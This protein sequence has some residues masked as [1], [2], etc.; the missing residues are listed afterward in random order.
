MR[1][2]VLHGVLGA[3]AALGT[4]Y[5]FGAVGLLAERLTGREVLNPLLAFLVLALAFGVGV[6]V[7][8]RQ[9]PPANRPLPPAGQASSDAG[10]PGVAPDRRGT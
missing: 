7:L 1:R 8:H 5:A 4:L 9:S 2:K 10:E 3:L 6:L